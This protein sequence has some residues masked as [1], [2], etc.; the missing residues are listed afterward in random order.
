MSWSGI[1]HTL[2]IDLLSL[3]SDVPSAT[4]DLGRDLP[5]SSSQSGGSYLSVGVLSVE[6]SG[7]Q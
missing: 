3:V 2:F 4:R 1:T 7:R 6:S 5:E